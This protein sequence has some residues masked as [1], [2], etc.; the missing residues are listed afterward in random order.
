M[1][2][3]EKVPA[4]GFALNRLYFAEQGLRLVQVAPEM[5]EKEAQISFGW[6]WRITGRRDF[7][8]ILQVRVGP[9][10]AR[11]E[12]AVV[13]LVGAFSVSGSNHSVATRDFVRA[14][15]PAI[16]FPYLREGLSAL[17]SRGAYGPNY[18]TPV[19]VLALMQNF[20]PD[21][22]TGALQLKSGSETDFLED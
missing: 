2:E 7:E 12:E 15:G 17:T 20:D 3:T 13:V 16:L 9:C 11:P 21:K 10:Q 1:K 22:A 18:L 4:A 8:V 5:P 6:D 14:Q 19:N